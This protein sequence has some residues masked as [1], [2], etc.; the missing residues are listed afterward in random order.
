[1]IFGG[2]HPIVTHHMN[3]DVRTA[4]SYN[5]VLLLSLTYAT[6]FCRV[7]NPQALKYVAVKFKPISHICLNL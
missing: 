2:V 7:D 1:M 4:V 3:I 5:K 6:Y